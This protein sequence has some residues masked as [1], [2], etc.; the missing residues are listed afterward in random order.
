ME[1]LTLVQYM[2]N[3]Q[4]ILLKMFLFWAAKLFELIFL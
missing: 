1:L 4:E 3:H 2:P